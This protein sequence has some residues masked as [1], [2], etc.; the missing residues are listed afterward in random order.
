MFQLSAY[1]CYSPRN[2]TEIQKPITQI[3]KKKIK[4]TLAKK[5]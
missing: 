3:V 4:K 5:Q 2:Q 1:F